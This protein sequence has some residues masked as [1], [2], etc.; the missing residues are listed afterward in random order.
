[1]YH[2]VIRTSIILVIIILLLSALQRFNKVSQPEEE[3]CDCPYCN[4]PYRRQM[5]AQGLIA[6]D[7]PC[8]YR[9]RRRGWGR[10]WG[11]RGRGWGTWRW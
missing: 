5:I 6:P 8:P 2:K 7:Q 3:Y 11:R 9:R 10:G 1:M 4:C